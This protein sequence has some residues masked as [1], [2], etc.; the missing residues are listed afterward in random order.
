MHLSTYTY[1]G[2]DPVH[3]LLVPSNKQTMNNAESPNSR[4]T[5][6]FNIQQHLAVWLNGLDVYFCQSIVFKV[7]D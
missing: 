1:M 3:P 6:T 4:F 7:K 5:T 2:K